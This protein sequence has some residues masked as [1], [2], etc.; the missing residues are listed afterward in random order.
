MLLART[1]SLVQSI[2]VLHPSFSG[3]CYSNLPL[4]RLLTAHDHDFIIIVWA[5]TSMH[6]LN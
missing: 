6:E 1:T 5:F 3:H 4:Q 2:V